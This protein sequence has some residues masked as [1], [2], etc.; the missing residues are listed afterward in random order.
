ME[1]LK[2][3][4]GLPLDHSTDSLASSGTRGV[5]VDYV[6]K[7]API[8]PALGR[9]RMPVETRPETFFVL[10]VVIFSHYAP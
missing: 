6:N 1:K 10:G 7:L 5:F 2:I 4:T 8:A 3:T 9:V